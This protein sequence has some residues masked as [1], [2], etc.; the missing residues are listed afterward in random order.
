MAI[1][2]RRLVMKVSDVTGKVATVPLTNDHTDGSW[3]DTDIY[4]GEFFWNSTDEILQQRSEIGI[5]NIGSVSTNV[6]IET[7]TESYTLA[8]SDKDKLIEVDDTVEI[9]ITVPPNSDVPFPIGSQILLARYGTGELD[10]AEGSGVTVLKA[11]GL[12]LNTQYSGATLIKR[13]T[14]EWYL[15]GDLKS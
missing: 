12:K 4:V 9:T 3:I 5:V 6:S 14:D 15:F 1:E 2:Y 13:A 8:L 11:V 7:K 10:I